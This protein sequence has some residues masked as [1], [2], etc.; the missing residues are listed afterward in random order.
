MCKAKDIWDYI[1]RL[2][3]RED[4]LLLDNKSIALGFIDEVLGIDINKN[5]EEIQKNYYD[6]FGKDI[7][8]QYIYEEKEITIQKSNGE[9]E[10]SSCQCV[11]EKIIKDFEMQ[12]D[13]EF[14]NSILE[15]SL[16]IKGDIKGIFNK[17]YTQAMKDLRD[18]NDTI[19]ECKKEL[20]NNVI[21]QYLKNKL[22]Y[23]I[24][25]NVNAKEDIYKFLS[26]DINDFIIN[27]IST[28]SPKLNSIFIHR[29][30]SC[31]GFGKY[32]N[33]KANFSLKVKFFDLSAGDR[34][35]YMK[36]NNKEEYY[37]YIEDYIEENRLVKY[38]L[39]DIRNNNLLYN[40]RKLLEELLNTYK[41]TEYM[42]FIA[43]GAIQIEGLFSDYLK[44]IDPKYEEGTITLVPKL[45]RIKQNNLFYGYEYFTF[46]FPRLRNKM[47]HGELLNDNDIKHIANE[48]F[49]DLRYVID[50]FKDK[51]L[52]PNMIFEVLEQIEDINESTLKCILA[53]DNNVYS[54]KYIF[55]NSIESYIYEKYGK[56]IDLI[57]INLLKSEFWRY[58]K[59]KLQKDELYI[60]YDN[61]N[62]DLCNVLNKVRDITRDCYNSNDHEKL[63]SYCKEMNIYIN[64]LNNKRKYENEKL[65]ELIHLQ[66]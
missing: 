35:P 27:D 54:Q 57:K 23:F 1:A 58:F 26:D 25:L 28:I 24:D 62:L 14:Y 49:L 53:L 47:A 11:K 2:K 22:E 20:N 51:Y 31:Y 61:I 36:Y 45:N 56:S 59:E 65:K 37:K 46:E 16:N 43:L 33:P 55:S 50:L 38:L 44:I 19:L 3:K 41:R 64:K 39:L 9:V 15:N 32:Y 30:Y 10:K 18:I 60:Y 21:D 17:Y 7:S 42:S 5:S 29:P 66:N 40:R 6:V 63:Y 13:D 52:K 48:V 12:S 34:E 4:F 8:A